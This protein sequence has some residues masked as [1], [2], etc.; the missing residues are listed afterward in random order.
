MQVYLVGGAVRDELLGRT[1]RERDWVVVGATAEQMQQLG[2]RAVGRDFPVFLHPQTR[3]EYALARQERKVGPGYR[4]FSAN[5]SPEVT[6]EQDLIR[7]DLTI[8]AIARSAEGQ[9]IDPYGGQ[10]D[11]E[12]RLLRHVSPAFVEDPVRVLRVARFAARFAQAGFTVAAETLA[13]MRQMVA[14]GE[15]A[16]LVAERAWREM[17]KALG[18]PNPEVFFEVLADCGALPVILPELCWNVASREAL[19]RASRADLSSATAGAAGNAAVDPEALRMRVCFA[20]LA[21]ASGAAAIDALCSR[22]RIPSDYRALALLAANSAATL[23]RAATLPAAQLLSTLEAADAFRR[24]ERFF[25]LLQT[26]L[27]LDPQSAVSLQWAR[28]A[29]ERAASC[30]LPAPSRGQLQGL[31]IAHALRALRLQCLEALPRPLDAVAPGG[32]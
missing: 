9:L 10:R 22:L 31:E 29:R 8:N 27:A 19:Q 7:R 20:T 17:A 2:Y 3:E 28:S 5:F 24:P 25:E 4:G 12:Q 6:L 23:S 30:S 18:E 11:L 15:V 1:V 21:H 16:H 13:L 14:C 32:T 26:A